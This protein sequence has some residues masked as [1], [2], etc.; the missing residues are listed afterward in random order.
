MFTLAD[1]KRKEKSAHA[2]RQDMDIERWIIFYK[3]I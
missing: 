3:I 2:V 1:K